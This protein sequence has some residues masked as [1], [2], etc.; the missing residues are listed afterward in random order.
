MD[1]EN[2]LTTVEL[3]LGLDKIRQSPKN[4]GSLELIVRRP[5]VDA[6]EV[7]SEGILNLT[8]G[9]AGDN[10]KIRGSS[11]TADGSS[12]PD[13]QL[14][15]MNSRLADLVAQSKERWQLAG[16]QLYVDLDLSVR[17]LPQGTQLSLGSAV[18]EITD[19]PHLGCKKFA[20]RFGASAL[21]FVN[22]PLG[23]QL[24][25][26]GVYAKV[27]HPGVTR[28]GEILRKV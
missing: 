16:D 5:K 26:R 22:S 15:L 24:R 19:Q 13:T 28:I 4:E 9:L 3:E 18:I 2:H 7:L 20:A 25:L 1:V 23:K 12:H 21:Q 14:T 10:W 27:V 8:E 17:N 11:R 6:R